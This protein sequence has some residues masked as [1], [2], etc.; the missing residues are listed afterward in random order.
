MSSSTPRPFILLLECSMPS[1]R[2]PAR[3]DQLGV[4]AVVA[5]VLVEDVAERVPVGRALHAQVQRV[6]GV[7][8]LVPVLLAGD[9]VGAGRQHL[10]DR[11]EAA[12]EQAGLRAVAVE[13]NAEREHL[14]G[15][16]QL[17]GVDDVLGRDVVERADVVVLAPA[18]PV[19]ELLRGFFDR[20][21]ADLDVHDSAR[22]A[23]LAL[24]R[25]LCRARE[26]VYRQIDRSDR[27]VN[28]LAH[29]PLSGT[30]DSF[31]SVAGMS[32]SASPSS[33]RTMLAPRLSATIL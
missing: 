3:V 2:E 19:R 6:V 29:Q 20:L 17:R 16:D 26:N 18:A 22:S 9:G 30:I 23:S 28:G 13:R 31:G 21:L 27:G 12:A 25:R 4:V 33:L 11:I 15:L 32:V 8:D 10:V 7:A 1:T 24:C 5:L 14:A